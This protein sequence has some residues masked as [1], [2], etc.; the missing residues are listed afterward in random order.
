MLQSE[1]RFWTADEDQLLRE[2]VD[3]ENPGN[4]TPSGW[5]A[6]CKHVPNRT[7]S[8]CRIRCFK[9]LDSGGWSPEQDV[10]LIH[11]MAKYGTCGRNMRE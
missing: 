11:A 2:A 10:Q 4:P 3:R 6:I 9:K 7:P 8:E 1:R 5:H